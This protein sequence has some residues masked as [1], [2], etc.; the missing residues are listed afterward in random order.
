MSR[1]TRNTHELSPE[2]DE[3]GLE[4]VQPEPGPSVVAPV[5]RKGQPKVIQEANQ[6]STLDQAKN[7]LDKMSAEEILAFKNHMKGPEE[8]E[9]LE[10]PGQEPDGYKMATDDPSA[11]PSLN[12][13][14]SEEQT[15]WFADPDDPDFVESYLNVAAKVDS[16]GDEVDEVNSPR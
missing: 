4:L 9:I 3:A 2:R 15:P 7:L 8:G 16:T 5:R 10:E 13:F 1:R 11:P 12:R 14:D 6:D